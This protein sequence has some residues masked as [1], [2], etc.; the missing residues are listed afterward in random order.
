M[1]TQTLCKNKHVTI[2]TH[3]KCTAASSRHPAP[4]PHPPPPPDGAWQSENNAQN[5][6]GSKR[7]RPYIRGSHTIRKNA[8]VTGLLLDF[9]AP[10]SLT[11]LHAAHVGVGG[12]T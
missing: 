6:P 5:V 2:Q 10:Y 3:N 8:A 1:H 4:P 7:R 11:E 12:A 9:G